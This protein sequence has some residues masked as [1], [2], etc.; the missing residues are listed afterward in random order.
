M[1]G[2]GIDRHLFAL[3]V[4]CRAA[5]DKSEFLEAALSVPWRLSTS[6]QPQIQTNL[7]ERLDPRIAENFA[8]PGGGFGPVDDLGYG[9]SYMI[10]GE[11][12]FYFHISASRAHAP[13]TDPARFA[14]RIHTALAEM[15]K[16]LGLRG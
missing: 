5:D 12:R 3:W 9:V 6:Q 2:K 16:L 11:D 13:E 14:Q 4:V 10:V 15:G 7:R 1:A 8:S